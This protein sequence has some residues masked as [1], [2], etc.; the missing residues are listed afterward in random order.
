MILSLGAPAGCIDG[1]SYRTQVLREE[2]VAPRQVGLQTPR[3]GLSLGRAQ[4]CHQAGGC[5]AQSRP[6]QARKKDRWPL[7]TEET[8][9]EGDEHPPRAVLSF[10][11]VRVGTTLCFIPANKEMHLLEN[12]FSPARA[13]SDLKARFRL[14]S[15][16]WFNYSEQVL[17]N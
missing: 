4:V 13:L 14:C 15:L 3:G 8:E 17:P 5:H 9:G 7:C 1:F 16:T 6:P 12:G 10:R 11:R 2:R